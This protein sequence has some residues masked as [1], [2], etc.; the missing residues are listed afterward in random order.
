MGKKVYFVLYLLLS[1]WFSFWWDISINDVSIRFCDEWLEKLD[2]HVSFYSKAWEKTE[3]CLMVLNNSENTGYIDLHFVSQTKTNQWEKACALPWNKEDIFVKYL[4]PSWSWLIYID[5]NS[6]EKKSFE[7]N[8]PVWIWWTQWWCL[9]FFMPDGKKS[10]T[11]TNWA[12]LSMI[13]R[14][15]SL[16]EVWIDDAKDFVNKL[17]FEKVWKSKRVLVF[18]N[19]AKSQIMFDNIDKTLNLKI[20]ANNVWNINQ[21]LNFSWKLHSILG[22]KKIFWM[23]GEIV[24]K[25]QNIILETEK[26]W[27]KLNIP[28]Y[29]WLFRFRLNVG[30]SPH[31]DFDT[32][33]IPKEKLIWVDENFNVIFFIVSWI[34]IGF[35]ILLVFV[36]FMIYRIFKKKI[37]IRK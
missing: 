4:K 36:L 8:F 37:I 7:I 11:E 33:R 17:V 34:S 22:Y 24:E 12:L 16:F 14:K 27:I 21:Q 10:N 28:E 3:W 32:S 6:E 2:K 35:R 26:K 9:A 5:K 18:R 25:D 1:I 29:H 20:K 19:G 15:A 13:T 23:D 31:F 30:I